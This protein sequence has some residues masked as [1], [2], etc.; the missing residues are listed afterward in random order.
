MRAIQIPRCGEGDKIRRLRRTIHT[1]GMKEGRI[2]KKALDIQFY[3]KRSVT[4]PRVR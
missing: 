4:K 3:E 1:Q 2:A